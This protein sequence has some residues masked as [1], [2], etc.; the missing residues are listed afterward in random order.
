MLQW[1][2]NKWVLLYDQIAALEVLVCEHTH[3]VAWSFLYDIRSFVSAHTV[4]VVLCPHGWV[5]YEISF[6][7]VAEVS[8]HVVNLWMRVSKGKWKQMMGMDGG[9]ARD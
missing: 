2:Q 7:N 8:G 9:R 3:A 5:R 1:E 6:N 4:F